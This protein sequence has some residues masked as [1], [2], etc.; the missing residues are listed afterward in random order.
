MSQKPTLG[1]CAVLKREPT[2]TPDWPTSKIDLTNYKIF[3]C[4]KKKTKISCLIAQNLHVIAMNGNNKSVNSNT[5]WG[6]FVM[7]R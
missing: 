3:H 2:I 5:T 4:N 7:A 6:P 1:N